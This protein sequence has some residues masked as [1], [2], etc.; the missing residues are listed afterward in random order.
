MSP[1]ALDIWLNF[2]CLLFCSS[3]IATVAVE[4][5]SNLLTKSAMQRRKKEKYNNKKKTI[6]KR[7][8]AIR[9]SKNCAYPQWLQSLL[10]I[11][12]RIIED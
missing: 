11:I 3:Y 6:K 10:F 8:L 4:R 1:L 12:F 7:L 9:I 2:L 5:A